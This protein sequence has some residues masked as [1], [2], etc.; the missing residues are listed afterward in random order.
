MIPSAKRY[1][2]NCDRYKRLKLEL[3]FYRSVTPKQNFKK[4]NGTFC[5]DF[6]CDQHDTRLT[7]LAQL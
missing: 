4:L 5:R 2:Q 6:D 3:Y 1:L 7:V